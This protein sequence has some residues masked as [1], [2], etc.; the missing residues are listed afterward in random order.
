MR[1]WLQ[2]GRA[3]EHHVIGAGFA[4]D[5]RLVPRLQ[6]AGTDD[7]AGVQGPQ[8]GLQGWP[9]A[10]DVDAIGIGA[11]RPLRIGFDEAGNAVV[12][13]EGS[14]GAKDLLFGA[15][16]ARRDS[17]KHA[18][19][20]AG[21]DRLEKRRISGRIGNRRRDQVKSRRVHWHGPKQL[22]GEIHV[23][24]Y[25]ILR[26]NYACKNMIL[27]KFEQLKRQIDLYRERTPA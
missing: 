10:F 15:V 24:S 18:G 25:W 16:A 26:R 11:A 9:G 6:S 14:Q 19:D 4:S 21:R 17:Q 27:S 20:V 2:A 7:V 22:Q 23:R 5:H 3:A 12:L 8:S 13:Q 1:M